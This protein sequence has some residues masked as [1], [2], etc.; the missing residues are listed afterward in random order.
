MVAL[1][2][3]C[4]YHDSRGLLLQFLLGVLMWMCS[5]CGGRHTERFSHDTL[6]Q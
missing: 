4:I 1:R 2:L 5:G 6:P 3:D